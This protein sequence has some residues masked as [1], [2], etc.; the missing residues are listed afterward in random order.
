MSDQMIEPVLVPPSAPNYLVT[1]NIAL[2]QMQAEKPMD[3]SEMDRRFA[4]AITDL[5]KLIAYAAVYMSV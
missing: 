2:E 4:I 5:E 1:L 3:R